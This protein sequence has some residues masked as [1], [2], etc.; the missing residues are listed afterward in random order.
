MTIIGKILYLYKFYVIAAFTEEIIMITIDTF[1]VCNIRIVIDV[2]IIAN[3]LGYTRG[4]CCNSIYLY[5]PF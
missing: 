3:E 4:L 5:R 2:I 1:I